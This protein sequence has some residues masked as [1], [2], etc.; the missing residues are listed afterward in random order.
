MTRNLIALTVL[1]CAS[2]TVTPASPLGHCRESHIPCTLNRDCG[3]ASWSNWCD[4]RV[5]TPTPVGC[6]RYRIKRY[7]YTGD[8]CTPEPD[9]SPEP[10][11]S[12]DDGPCPPPR[13]HMGWTY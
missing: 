5:A 10:A 8:I 9:P 7:P 1:L 2:S 12:T 11:C 3:G 6:S 13:R 4:Y